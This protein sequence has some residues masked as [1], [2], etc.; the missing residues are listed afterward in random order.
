VACITKRNKEPGLPITHSSLLGRSPARSSKMARSDTLFLLAGVAIMLF[1]SG[2]FTQPAQYQ[3]PKAPPQCAG[4]NCGKAP[5]I[6]LGNATCWNE[7]TCGGAPGCFGNIPRWNRNTNST[8]YCAWEP[9]IPGFPC[10]NQ[11]NCSLGNQGTCV[12]PGVCL[13]RVPSYLGICLGANITSL[14]PLGRK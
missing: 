13:T 7:T 11:R 6:C 3:G 2:V 8:V 12:R 10:F 4:F 14:D 1:A 5:K 9:I